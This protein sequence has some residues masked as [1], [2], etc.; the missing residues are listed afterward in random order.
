MA[1]S[2]LS[3]EKLPDSGDIHLWADYL[4]LRCLTNSDLT[5]SK[6]DLQSYAKKRSDLRK[7]LEDY[8]DEPELEPELRR[9]PIDLK[10]AT[11][12]EDLFK[13]LEYRASAFADFYPF[14][15]SNGGDILS[16]KLRLTK[17]HML[18]LFF[19]LSSNLRHIP[20]RRHRNRFADAFEIVSLTALKG[21]LP[22]R[23]EVHLFGTN[24]LKEKS[25]RYSV[26]L[27]L[28]RIKRLAADLKEN[29]IGDESDFAPNDCGDNGLDVVGWI[30]LDDNARGFLLVFGQCAC[31]DDEWPTKQA[32]SS[33]AHWRKT[34][35][36]LAPPNNM[37]F[38]PF[39]YRRNRGEWHRTRTIDD[40]IL[41]DRLRLV[42]LLEG[43]Y[44]RLKSLP[45]ELINKAV[46][47]RELWI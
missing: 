8:G 26:P 30:P 46:D 12:A 38:I 23:A 33:L 47:Q 32:S 34:M 24:S 28:E 9:L 36:F 37:I 22:N 17:K 7:G 1:S 41:I 19:L 11:R 21:Y 15:L 13:H 45:F 20:D 10:K 18:Y 5:V 25:E 43:S 3:L 2:F 14:S 42:K 4:E 39:C 44:H 31:S 6:S 40:A 27:L 16:R 29:F 35:T